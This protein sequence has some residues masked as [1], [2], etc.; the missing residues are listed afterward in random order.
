MRRPKGLND[1]QTEPFYQQPCVCVSRR[2]QECNSKWQKFVSD[3]K[4]MEAWLADAKAALELAETQ[5]EA[6]RQRLRVTTPR[7]H[8]KKTQTSQRSC[9]HTC[10]INRHVLHVKIHIYTVCTHVRQLS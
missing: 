10:T 3:Q 1:G 4:A 9:V 7:V 2:W 8:N 6:Q 5:P